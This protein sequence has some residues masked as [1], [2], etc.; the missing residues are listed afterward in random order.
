MSIPTT[1]LAPKLP[2]AADP[3]TQYTGIRDYPGIALQNLKMLILTIP[4]ERIMDN[5]FG[6][7]LPAYL[8]EMNDMIVRGRISAKIHEQVNKYLPFI[9]ILDISYHSSVE[10]PIVSEEYLGIKITFNI[11]PISQTRALTLHIN[12]SDITAVEELVTYST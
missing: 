8:F 2:L 6:V 5:E 10:D 11:K 3:A 4:S 7:G 9:E 1:L 12:G